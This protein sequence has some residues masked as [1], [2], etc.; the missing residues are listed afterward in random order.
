[1]RGKANQFFI[2]IALGLVSYGLLES[3]LAVVMTLVGLAVIRGLGLNSH[4]ISK[5]L[6]RLVKERRMS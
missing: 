3:L 6:A 1:M 2:G 5:N 4:Q